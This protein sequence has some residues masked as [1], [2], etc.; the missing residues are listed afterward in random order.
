MTRMNSIAAGMILLAGTAAMTGC[1]DAAKRAV[2]RAPVPG[3]S[4][5]VVKQGDPATP[6]VPPEIVVISNRAP[7]PVQLSVLPVFAPKRRPF[8]MLPPPPTGSKDGVIARSGRK[9]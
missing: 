8:L 2:V 7:T 5:T 1:E 9:F 6:T 4:I 3:S